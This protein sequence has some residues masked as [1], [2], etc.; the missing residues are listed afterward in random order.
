MNDF[1]SRRDAIE[2]V[3]KIVPYVIDK[4]TGQ[5]GTL[6]NKANVITE[7]SALPSDEADRPTGEWKV[8]GHGMTYW[9]ECDQ[10]G[11]AG[12]M[13]DRFCKHCG[14]RMDGNT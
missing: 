7:L 2:A 10:C 13:Q 1:I 6:V 5:W 3:R 8:H 9:Y 12:D 4:D 11:G 14:A